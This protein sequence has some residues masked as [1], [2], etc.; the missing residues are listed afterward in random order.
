MGCGTLYIYC[1]RKEE[2]VGVLKFRW[3]TGERGPDSQQ[4]LCPG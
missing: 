3:K 2:L 4:S 1:L